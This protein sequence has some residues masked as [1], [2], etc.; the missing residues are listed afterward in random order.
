MLASGP[1]GRVEQRDA[2]RRWSVVFPDV[3]HAAYRRP[4][5]ATPMPSRRPSIQGL[6]FAASA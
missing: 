1:M 3:E 6:N 4:A 5:R 2:G